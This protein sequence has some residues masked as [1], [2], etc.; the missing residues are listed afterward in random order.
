M[1][2]YNYLDHEVWNIFYYIYNRNHGNGWRYSQIRAKQKIFCVFK[3]YEKFC[4]D[5][6]T[7]YHIG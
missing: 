4:L 5:L 2:I 7:I 3:Y 1:Y 6:Q